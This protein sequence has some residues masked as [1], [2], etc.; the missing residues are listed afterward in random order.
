MMM[1]DPHSFLIVLVTMMKFQTLKVTAVC[2]FKEEG[3]GRRT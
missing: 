2:A 3:D 1:N